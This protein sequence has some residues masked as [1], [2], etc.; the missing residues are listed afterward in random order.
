MT[1]VENRIRD[2]PASSAVSEPTAPL[3][4]SF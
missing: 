3:L 4:Q 2:I 1:P